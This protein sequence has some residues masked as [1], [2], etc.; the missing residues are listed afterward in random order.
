[1]SHHD[2]RNEITTDTWLTPKWVMDALG[3]FDLDPCAAPHPRPWPTAS[4]HYDYSQGMDG[5]TLP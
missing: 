3:V 1:M 4:M 2:S 5:L